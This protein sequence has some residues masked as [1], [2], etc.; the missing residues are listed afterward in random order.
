[1]PPGEWSVGIDVA[2]AADAG[3]IPGDQ[4][5]AAVDVVAGGATISRSARRWSARPNSRVS[6]A[7]ARTAARF[8]LPQTT[9][10]VEFRLRAEGGPPLITRLAVDLRPAEHVP[11]PRCRD[12]A[13]HTPARAAQGPRRGRRG[14]TRA[15]P[16]ADH[17]NAPNPL[18][19]SRPCPRPRSRSRPPRRR[20]A[21]CAPPPS[22]STRVSK[23][24]RIPHEQVTR[25]RSVRCTRSAARGTTRCTRC[26]TSPSPSG[27]ASSSASSGA[28]ARARARC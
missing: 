3:T 1:M 19:P 9:M 17:E 6:R 22:R 8:S 24:F 18:L 7:G 13:G 15:G 2:L 16:G 20:P 26:A 23:T 4:V 10:G 14:H 27:R 11:R 25:S 28:T 5:V 21:Q 12:P